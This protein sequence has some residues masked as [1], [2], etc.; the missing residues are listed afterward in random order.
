MEALRASTLAFRS[1]FSTAS[2]S[3]L[4]NSSLRLYILD[5]RVLI[6]DRYSGHE[7]RVRSTF[8]VDASL[9][10]S[11]EAC[12]G[13]IDEEKTP[14]RSA[15]RFCTV[16]EVWLLRKSDPSAVELDVFD[17]LAEAVFVGVFVVREDLGV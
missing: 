3:F 7:N 9:A 2:F 16:C 8:L 6:D 15:N 13:R 5:Q 14:T 10:A 12:R 4:S 17:T 11:N 1:A